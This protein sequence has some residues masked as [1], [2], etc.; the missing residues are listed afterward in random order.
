M[1]FRYSSSSSR[2]I[3]VPCNMSFISYDIFA[4][5]DVDFEVCFVASYDDGKEPEVLMA[6]GPMLVITGGAD[7]AGGGVEVAVEGAAN[8]AFENSA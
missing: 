7:G 8:L 4:L 1:L 2:S 6:G 3:P 5:P